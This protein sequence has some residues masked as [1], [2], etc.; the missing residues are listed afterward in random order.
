MSETD[1]WLKLYLAR[2][3]A[4]I[5][6]NAS[7]L[8]IT[9][10]STLENTINLKEHMRRT[11]INEQ[12][13]DEQRVAI[14]AATEDY[15]KHADVLSAKIDARLKP[16]EASLHGFLGV[17]KFLLIAGSAIGLIWGGIQIAKFFGYL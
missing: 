7:K 3:E 15:R 8:D 1:D 4:K 17:N 6:V 9:T 11:A 2:I 14:A 16:I 10:I 5:D 12:R 13:L